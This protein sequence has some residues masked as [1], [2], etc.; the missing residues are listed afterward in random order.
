MLDLGIDLVVWP[1]VWL[2]I[3]VS[4]ALIEVT[5]LGGSFILLPFAVSALIAAVLGFYDVA[6]EV[7]WAVFLIGGAILWFG[8]Y[9][10]AKKFLKDNVLPPGVGA[11]RLIGMP[12]IVTEAIDPNDTDRLG[13]ITVAG[14]VWGA[15]ASHDEV[16]AK[17][18]KV[19]ITH[20]QGTRVIV[21]PVSADE[22]DPGED[23][24]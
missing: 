2:F 4:F 13:R 22:S 17:G 6:I 18:T 8:F 23:H 20:M 1:W 12:A 21:E 15:T 16:L 14:E 7:Q 3:A 11:D 19:R 10:W 24:Q 9:R 5:L